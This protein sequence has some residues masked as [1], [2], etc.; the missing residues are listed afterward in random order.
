MPQHASTATSGIHT[1]VRTPS[2]DGVLTPFEFVGASPA[3][4]GRTVGLG[5]LIE[6]AEELFLD[7]QTELMV[8][9]DY[10]VLDAD[11]ESVV[12]KSE[13]KRKGSPKQ[14]AA[15]AEAKPVEEDDGFELI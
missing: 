7:K 13:K 12:L 8:K 3:K 9:E 6:K 10:E 11:G 14:K 4:K 2:D 1:T 15:T 5:G